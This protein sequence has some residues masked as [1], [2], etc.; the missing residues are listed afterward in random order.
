MASPLYHEDVIYLVKDG[1]IL[2]ALDARTGEA[3]KRGRLKGRGNYYASPI[4]ADGKIYLASEQ[5]VITVVS[6]SDEWQI[7]DSFDFGEMIYA[8]PVVHQG[9]LYVRTD[10]ALYCFKS[11]TN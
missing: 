4:Y 5:G 1:G 2:T 7:L 9:R 3:R 6:A 11:S 8:T 10:A